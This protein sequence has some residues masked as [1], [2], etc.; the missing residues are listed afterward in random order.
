MF[1]PFVDQYLSLHTEI[2][3]SIEQDDQQAIAELDRRTVELFDQILQHQP[4]SKPEL[5]E[6][7]KFLMTELVRFEESS[8]N[9][10][11]ICTRVVGLIDA[12][13]PD[14][15]LQT[16]PAQLTEHPVDT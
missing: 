8:P 7:C 1:I 5:I 12:F 9:R 11:R 4:G 13:V 2:K 15:S 14:N 6:L 10:E 3:Q 16:R